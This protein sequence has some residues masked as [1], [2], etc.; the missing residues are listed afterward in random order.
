MI[1]K[2]KLIQI[3]VQVFPLPL[4]QIPNKH[5]NSSNHNLSQQN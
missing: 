5:C 1:L 3:P 2:M 4:N